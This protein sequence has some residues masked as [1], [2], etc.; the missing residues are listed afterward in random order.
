VQVWA[1]GR[2]ICRHWA[3]I[4][5]SRLSIETFKATHL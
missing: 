3:D 1:D 4:F 2:K 5:S